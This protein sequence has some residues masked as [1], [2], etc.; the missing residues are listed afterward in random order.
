MAN[1]AALGA[2][3]AK[4]GGAEVIGVH[5]HGGRALGAAVAFERTNAEL[6]LERSRKAIRKLFRASH[7]DAQAAE[8]FRRT[9]AQVQLQESWRS[10]QEGDLVLAD[11]RADAFGIEWIRI[12]NH[13]HPQRRR[14]TKR[15]GKTERMKE[16]QDTQQSV[17]ASEA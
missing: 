17:P 15:S 14:S 16:W 9:T 2:D 13:A 10:Q 4:T 12:K 7:H 6:F 1:L 8:I 11:Q 5:C 3:L